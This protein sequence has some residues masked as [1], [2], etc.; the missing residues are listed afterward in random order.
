MSNASVSIDEIP[1]DIV[2]LGS[3][4]TEG[5]GLLFLIELGIFVFCVLI[6]WLSMIAC[7]FFTTHCFGET[8]HCHE[9]LIGVYI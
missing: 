6:L 2:I 7:V 8:D 1:D 3:S 5:V 9:P 4:F